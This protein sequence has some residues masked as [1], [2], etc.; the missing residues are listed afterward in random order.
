MA[1]PFERVWGSGLAGY[2]GGTAQAFNLLPYYPPE[3]GG[4]LTLRTESD[5]R[6][7]GLSTVPVVT[8][9]RTGRGLG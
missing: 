6:R 8:V 1:A 5:S 3:A 9:V 2:S 4:T 7:P